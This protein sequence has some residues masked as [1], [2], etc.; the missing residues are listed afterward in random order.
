[1]YSKPKKPSFL[2][3]PRP[4]IS[5]TKVSMDTPSSII[6]DRKFDTAL[7]ES[8]LQEHYQRVKENDMTTDDKLIIECQNYPKKYVGAD[9]SSTAIS[10]LFLDRYDKILL[11][12]KLKT[13]DLS[14]PKRVSRVIKL[15]HKNIQ[16]QTEYLNKANLL[17][18]VTLLRKNMKHMLT[19]SNYDN[20]FLVG[21]ID[22]ADWLLGVINLSNLMYSDYFK[23]LDEDVFVSELSK[24]N[25]S[26]YSGANIEISWS[27]HYCIVKINDYVALLPKSYIL[28][29]HNKICDLISIVIYTRY[30]SHS[31]LPKNAEQTVLDFCH[32]L[33]EL[34]LEYG[35]QFYT[36]SKCLEGLASAETLIDVERWDNT[37]FLLRINKDILTDTGFN[38]IQSS[39]R[40]MLKKSDI[41]FRH[42]LAALSKICGHP[43]VDMEQGAHKIYKHTNEVYDLDYDKI[44]E[45]MCYV[46][47][48]YIRNHIVRE[49]KWPVTKPL[50]IHAPEG[51]RIAMLRNLDPEG[52]SITSKYGKID[53][54]AYGLIE[55][56]KN[57]KYHKLENAIP[58]LKDKTI[59]VLRSKV[60][61]QYIK[62]EDMKS[63]WKETRLL[64]F[65]LT[66]TNEATNHMEFIDN[67]SGSKDISDFLDYLVIRI[68]PKEKE[69]KVA[70]RGFGCT[71][72]MNRMLFLSQ[73]KTAMHY[74]DLYSDEQAMTLS[75]LDLV[76][77]LFSF[78][79]LKRAYPRHRV[80]YV[81][82]DADK[83]NNHFR[84]ETVDDIMVHT[85]DKIHG[86]NIFGRTQQ[87]YTKTLFYV[88]DSTTTYYW[89]G[90][91]GGI[92]GLNQDTWVITYIAQIKTAL[93][94]LD[95]KYHI[96]C[97]GDDLRIAIVVPEHDPR[98]LDIKST[99]E[100]V[101]KK[102]AKA[103]EG[104]GHKIKI[105]DSYGSERYFN[106]SK[107]AS[108]DNIELPQVFRK[109]QKC[110]GA[111]N[112]FLPTLDEFIGSTF[113]NAHSACRVTTNQVPCYI[114]A[115]FWSYYYLT[116]DKNIHKSKTRPY[117]LTSEEQ[118][119]KVYS[120]GSCT[121]D[122]L[123]AM[124]LVP[125]LLGGF[126]IIYLHNM[127]VRSECD[128]LPPFLDMLEFA[129]TCGYNQLYLI[130][131]N[132][133]KFPLDKITTW[134]P[135][136]MDP[137]C[138]PLKRPQTSSQVLRSYMIPA[139]RKITKAED[140]QE[141]LEAERDDDTSSKYIAA[142]D[143]SQ[144]C[145]AKVFSVLYSTFP[146][147][148]LREFILKFESSRSVMELLLLR[149]TQRRLNRVLRNVVKTDYKSSQWKLLKLKDDQIE[150]TY[151]YY[152][153]FSKCPA[154]FAQKIRDKAWGKEIDGITMPPM[155]HLLAFTTQFISGL[156]D[157]ARANHFNFTIHQPDT[158][159][160]PVPNYHYA[161]GKQV[162]FIG[163]V[164]GTGTDNPQLHLVEKDI[165]LNKIRNI[166]ELVSW[167]DITEIKDDG[168]QRQS[169][170]R[171]LVEGI[172]KMYT[173]EPL[174]SIA[175]FHG[176]RKSG[177][178]AH[179]I[180]LRHFREAVIPNCLS[181]VYQLCT[182]ESNTHSLFYGNS[183]HYWIN[184]LQCYCHAVSMITFELNFSPIFT[185]PYTVWSVTADC[186]YCMRSVY[187][188]AVVVDLSK[189][190]NAYFPQLLVTK[191]SKHA[192]HV[193]HESL[194]LSRQKK[195]N[196]SGHSLDLQPVIATVGIFQMLCDMT[197]NQQKRLVDRYTQH[198]PTRDGYQV[199]RNFVPATGHRVIGQRELCNMDDETLRDCVIFTV[200]HLVSEHFTMLSI[201]NL[202]SALKTFPPYTLPWHS[203]LYELHRVGRLGILME[204]IAKLA[205]TQ[206][207]GIQYTPDQTTALLGALC[208]QALP[209]MMN[210][211]PLVFLSNYEISDM[212]NLL[213]TSVIKS[214]WFQYLTN[215]F[216]LILDGNRID[217]VEVSAYI[218][219][220]S[221]S[222]NPL[223][224]LLDPDAT[225][226]LEHQSISYSDY[227]APNLDL[228]SDDEASLET[229]ID[230]YKTF[231]HT[232]C[233]VLRKSKDP[234]LEFIY[235]N[236]VEVREKAS[237][238]F[239]NLQT[240][241]YWT[242]ALA[243]I[244]TIR[245]QPNVFSRYLDSQV[246]TEN[247]PM[248]MNEYF[249]VVTTKTYDSPA[250]LF[251]EPDF[252]QCISNLDINIEYDPRINS[253][254]V[255]QQY[256]F[257]AYGS[258]NNTMNHLTHIYEFFQYNRKNILKHTGYKISC[259]GDGIGNGTAFLATMHKKSYF[260][261][262]TKPESEM[263]HA[264][265][266]VAETYLTDY[267]STCKHDHNLLGMWDLRAE[268]TYD[269]LIRE[270]NG[271][272][273]YFCDAE[274]A[275]YESDF[276]IVYQ[277]VIEYY[278][279][280]RYPSSLLIMQ[281][282][283]ANIKELAKLITV[284]IR[285]CNYV[286]LFQSDS[287]RCFYGYYLIVW[288]HKSQYIEVDWNNCQIPITIFSHMR[289]YLEHRY[290]KH[291]QLR[292][293]KP[294]ILNLKLT[295]HLSF[296]WS[297]TLPALWLSYA[298]KEL[299]TTID[300]DFLT[301]LF[302]Y[303]TMEEI[304][305]IN[306]I[307]S[308]TGGYF[309]ATLKGETYQHA[310]RNQVYDMNTRTHRVFIARLFMTYEGWSTLYHLYFYKC[311]RMIPE[312]ELRQLFYNSCCKLPIRDFDPNISYINIYTGRMS[313]PTGFDLNYWEHFCRGMEI[314]MS[315]I[316]WLAGKHRVFSR[317][318]N[319][320]IEN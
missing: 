36:I 188:P 250:I 21:L 229:F 293:L 274:P 187:E 267:D 160:T 94:G 85:L 29:L 233:S 71:T 180:R 164:T 299:N 44:Y 252:D 79:N 307:G 242:T 286:Y 211:P 168:T 127:M 45:C 289:K 273:I 241:F 228:L 263:H 297:V 212:V 246:P 265:P 276:H 11:N 59:S 68:V 131:R 172:I 5:Q 55:L 43:F 291:Y 302:M 107:T 277:K 245:K 27:H 201:G 200:V 90:Q 7:R 91:S 269:Y 280:T 20:N 115:L 6:F 87:K 46:K 76:K 154:E 144:I 3:E 1:M 37:E 279:K 214:L 128:L 225:L 50:P 254:I 88:P 47:Q 251:P 259:M 224:H 270:Y 33:W 13:H 282:S 158:Y 123:V 209:Y 222:Y 264:Y 184:F 97:K 62:S 275:P 69:L 61:Q 196:L 26:K 247:T 177:T 311:R 186:S 262:T 40:Q 31:T 104:L 117:D 288:G 151:D 42:E 124:T 258:S 82:V 272:H 77:R 230:T 292:C 271:H 304:R 300:D 312:S 192:Q 98:S 152:K 153:C 75:E 165:I 218:V 54:R 32:E 182:G 57:L 175:P 48:N 240:P 108:V 72:F 143:G 92:E 255:R 84:P 166:A 52:A 100:S 290:K 176:N 243:C 256:C 178:I 63:S 317:I 136:Y 65:Y 306:P 236:P 53:I 64:L 81:M 28:L 130:M 185:T 17:P 15:A 194:K 89:E 219:L 159:L 261:F 149:S 99:K 39:I 135:V 215:K 67:Y 294:R 217:E 216:A 96:L 171:P 174:S 23:T 19:S 310:Y 190:K 181:N 260:V 58:Y 268:Y 193:L 106:F 199:L 137:Y 278:L 139:L 179:H 140:I 120:F 195:Y 204:N 4:F 101:M 112:A 109:I 114:V 119:Q 213:T 281:V 232:V 14:Q 113:S 227:L 111:S 129:K 12:G 319:R 118:H 134:K 308:S 2:F 183:D 9:K 51:L 110:Y 78:R 74:L 142:M 169:N 133:L 156:N 103:A 284:C 309:L 157:H 147:S 10:R 191:L 161:Q 248:I 189:I 266:C 163:H 18:S 223:E 231:A 49:G 244:E 198:P 287:E 249:K 105:Y 303:E 80:I 116:S 121:D 60:V 203:L 221:S 305:N 30:A 138:L 122:E 239:S 197:I 70:F 208:Y 238:I 257:R 202:E 141:L 295:T 25:Y 315:Y 234:I 35:Q 207:V 298:R 296:D 253:R 24:L 285:Q 320:D 93:S 313:D 38:Y 162:P 16:F 150:E 83:W 125:G 56:E 34:H 220:L 318:K 146:E 167:S 73:E 86:T 132:F 283:S 226:D 145:H 173:D 210:A 170:L 22:C 66:N 314:F 235:Q 205:N 148:V 8:H 126:P 102:L 301:K 95:L 316:A 237:S 206:I 41:A 155:S